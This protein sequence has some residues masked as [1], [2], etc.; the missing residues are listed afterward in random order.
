MT[1]SEH[2]RIQ[3]QLKRRGSKNMKTLWE[4]NEVPL[5]MPERLLENLQELMNQEQTVRKKTFDIRKQFDIRQTYKTEAW[6]C[7]Q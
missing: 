7:P 5:A 2:L 1:N 3:L 4:P 6:T